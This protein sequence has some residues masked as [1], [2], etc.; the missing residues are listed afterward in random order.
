MT[1]QV[2][3]SAEPLRTVLTQVI[4]TFGMCNAMSLN[5]L[6]REELFTA[7]EAG[8]S[9]LSGVLGGPCSRV[10]FQMKQELLLVL[11]LLFT[12]AAREGLTPFRPMYRHMCPV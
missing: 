10:N 1:S 3:L 6:P 2:V 9:P 8:V 12:D 11:K 7:I 5:I 4:L